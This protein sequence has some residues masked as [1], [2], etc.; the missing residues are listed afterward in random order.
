MIPPLK[1]NKLDVWRAWVYS[2][3]VAWD[4]ALATKVFFNNHRIT[5]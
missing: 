5:S 2:V 4:R 1:A 3:Q